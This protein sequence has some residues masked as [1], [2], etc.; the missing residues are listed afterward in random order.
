MVLKGRLS[1]YELFYH[2]SFALR[3][4]HVSNEQLNHVPA[5]GKSHIVNKWLHPNV[6][7][8]K[9]QDLYGPATDLR[10]ID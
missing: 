3:V 1:P 2:L 7:M 10:Y 8:E 9:V 5:V 6:T 4:T